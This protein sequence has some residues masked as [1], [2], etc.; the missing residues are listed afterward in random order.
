MMSWA[1][2][3]LCATF[4]ASSRPQGGRAMVSRSETGGFVRWSQA[5]EIIG[6]EIGRFRGVAWFQWVDRHFVWRAS[7]CFSTPAEDLGQTSAEGADRGKSMCFYRTEM[8]LDDSGVV[9]ILFA[10]AERSRIAKS[11]PQRP[12]LLV[13]PLHRA[14]P[15]P[16]LREPRPDSPLTPALSPQ[17]GRGGSGGD[18]RRAQNALVARVLETWWHF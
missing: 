13:S 12:D 15:G 2:L 10:A 6:R 5:L 9:K 14:K 4:S 11:P 7:R 18:S 8:I 16:V 17:A 1:Y 3:L